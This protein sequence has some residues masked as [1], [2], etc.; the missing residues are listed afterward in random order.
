[1]FERTPLPAAV[2][3][4]ASALS[5][6]RGMPARFSVYVS[7]RLLAEMAFGLVL[8]AR[9]ASRDVARGSLAD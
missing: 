5:R 2:R 3:E 1:M 9:D 8:E 4:F 7:E 6:E